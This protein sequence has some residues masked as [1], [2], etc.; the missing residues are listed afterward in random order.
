M[1][2]TTFL[3]RIRMKAR[4]INKDVKG[5]KLWRTKEQVYAIEN[6]YG[7][8]KIGR[9]KDIVTR[10]RTIETQGCIDIKKKWVSP[11]CTNANTIEK[12]LHKIFRSNRIKGEWFKNGF[13][14]IVKKAECQ[15]YI[16]E[17]KNLGDPEKITKMF[18][19]FKKPDLINRILSTQILVNL[20]PFFNDDEHE[21]HEE[22][23]LLE[24]SLPELSSIENNLWDIFY[25][26]YNHA[27]QAYK[28]WEFQK[29][30]SID[31]TEK[32]LTKEC[33]LIKGLNIYN[34]ITQRLTIKSK[35]FDNYL[36]FIGFKILGFSCRN[37]RKYVNFKFRLWLKYRE[38]KFFGIY[39]FK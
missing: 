23:K 16:L 14:A 21:E 32:F 19:Q 13:N 36:A 22:E 18:E 3:K 7:Q 24:L 11:E 37:F 39:L 29:W 15:D 35:S 27:N 5:F 30:D 28:K 9:S 38:K 33:H 2:P 12:D 17:Y 34:P 6:Q 26:N 31:A 10:F 8:V 25:L 20:S 4:E 1:I